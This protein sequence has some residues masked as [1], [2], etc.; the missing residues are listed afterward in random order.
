MSNTK[1][2]PVA[3]TIYWPFLNKV[4]EMSG[5]YQVDLAQLSDAAVEALTMMGLD[6][7]NKGDDRGNFITAKSQYPIEVSFAKHI[8]SIDPS[9]IGNDTKA[10]V[11]LSAYSWKY[12]GKQ[13]VSP[14][15][16]KLLIT[17]VAIHDKG[18]DLE[19]IDL[20]AAI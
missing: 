18:G 17:E 8:D 1:I 12:M 15:I 11:A 14:S 19:G 16:K 6:V 2:V 7:R 20:D 9:M 4:N 10:T 13:G 3:A 5:K